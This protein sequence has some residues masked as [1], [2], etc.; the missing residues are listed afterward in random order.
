VSS[1]VR[2]GRSRAQAIRSGYAEKDA[3]RQGIT[4]YN[5]VEAPEGLAEADLQYYAPD[6]MM[7][8]HARDMKPKSLATT[9]EAAADQSEA[10]RLRYEDRVD[11]RFVRSLADSG[12]VRQLYG[13]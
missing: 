4:P 13:E 3:T 12:S 10:R 8:T 1:G 2:S 5:E 7:R 6:T 9:I 11:D